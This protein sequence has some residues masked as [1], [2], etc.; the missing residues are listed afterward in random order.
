MAVL[1]LNFNPVRL[2]PDLAK[3]ST[4][5][6]STGENT[7][8]KSNGMPVNIILVVNENNHDKLLENYLHCSELGI[9][10]VSLNKVFVTD[11][12]EPLGKEYEEEC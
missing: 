3:E 8:A 10:S 2:P 12:S 5:P 9:N 7:G 6:E 4:T 11:R 1:P